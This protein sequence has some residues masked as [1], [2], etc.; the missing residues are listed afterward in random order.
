[1][2]R[3]SQN[4]MRFQHQGIKLCGV[5][6]SFLNDVQQNEKFNPTLQHQLLDFSGISFRNYFL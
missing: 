4:M 3:I 6:F 2:Y 1:M 5:L